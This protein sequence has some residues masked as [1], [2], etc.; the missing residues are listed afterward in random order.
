MKVIIA[1]GRDLDEDVVYAELVKLRI[2]DDSFIAQA[3]EIVSGHCPT[4]A[5]AAGEWYADF[6]DVPTKLFPADWDKHGRAA[7]P[8]RN[9]QMAE[10]ADAL[11]AFWDGKSRGT[12]GM[13]DLMEKANKPVTIIKM[14]N[15]EK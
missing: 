2:E 14:E 8:I 7:G 13:I 12:K 10:Y 11:V 9:E 5:D 3:T 6:Y 1:G 15:L 4:G